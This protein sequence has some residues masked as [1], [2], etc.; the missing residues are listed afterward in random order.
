MNPN[1]NNMR[2]DFL[3]AAQSLAEKLAASEPFIRFRQT[4]AALSADQ[5]A[6]DLLN[7][8]WTS[9]DELRT[10]QQNGRL[11]Q[12]DVDALRKIQNEV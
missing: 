5:K 12:R 3:A 7:S 9:Q 8:L 4:H 2:A 10:R 6:L 11:Q 1:E